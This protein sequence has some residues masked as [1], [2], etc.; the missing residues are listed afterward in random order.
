M[1]MEKDIDIEWKT[2][3]VDNNSSQGRPYK[4]EFLSHEEIKEL[5]KDVLYED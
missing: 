1:K 2:W 5:E 3:F 4:F